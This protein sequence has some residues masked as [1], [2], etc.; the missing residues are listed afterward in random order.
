ME[1]EAKKCCEHEE[2]GRPSTSITHVK[3]QLARERDGSGEPT[4]DYNFLTVLIKKSSKTGFASIKPVR[5]E[6]KF[7]KAHKRNRM[8][9]G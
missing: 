1:Q 9:I 3:I 8:D 2:E 6:R 7:T 5:N 4:R